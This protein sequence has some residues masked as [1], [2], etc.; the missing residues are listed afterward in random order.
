MS[1][2]ATEPVTLERGRYR[3]SEAPD[4]GWVL[5]RATSTCESCQSCGCGEAAELV[6]IPA[7]VI[8]MAR[9][10]GGMLGKLKD[11]MIPGGGTDG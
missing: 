3:V 6:H 7:M 5:A 2:T 4:G 10:Q 1:E 8:K 11:K 9:A